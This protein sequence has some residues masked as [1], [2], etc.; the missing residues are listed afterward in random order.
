MVEKLLEHMTAL[1]PQHYINVSVETQLPRKLNLFY[2]P[3]ANQ[4]ATS[5][6]QTSFGTP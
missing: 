6:L 4:F 3:S 1:C 5:K 2:L